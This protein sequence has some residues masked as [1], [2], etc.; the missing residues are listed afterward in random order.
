MSPL[1][2]TR[3]ATAA[4]PARKAGRRRARKAGKKSAY[5]MGL[6]SLIYWTKFD[7][8]LQARFRANQ[9]AVMKEFG[10]KKKQQAAVQAVFGEDFKDIMVDLDGIWLE[11]GKELLIPGTSPAFW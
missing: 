11:I 10:L 4:K 6:I 5:P 8:E 1:K 9:K 3:I 2:K 7:R